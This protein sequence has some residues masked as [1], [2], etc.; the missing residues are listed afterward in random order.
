MGLP[1]FSA[2]SPVSSVPDQLGK[3]EPGVESLVKLAWA[4]SRDT[5]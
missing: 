1:E 3:V 5:P 4:I 2:N